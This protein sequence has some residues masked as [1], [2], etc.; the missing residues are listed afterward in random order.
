MGCVKQRGAGGTSWPLTLKRAKELPSA[1]L[2]HSSTWLGQTPPP[3]GKA[4]EL[5]RFHL[6]GV[7]ARK[8]QCDFKP[9]D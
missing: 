2:P 4:A 1:P 7:K 3:E 9:R 6:N 5:E 8:P